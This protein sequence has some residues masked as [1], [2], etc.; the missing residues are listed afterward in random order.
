VRLDRGHIV[1]VDRLWSLVHPLRT[2]NA[3]DHQ[4]LRLVNSP[5]ESPQGEVHGPVSYVA[6]IVSFVRTTPRSLLL[7]LLGTH[8]QCVGRSLRSWWGVRRRARLRSGLG[9][10][11]EEAPLGVGGQGGVQHPGAERAERLDRPLGVGVAS[12]DV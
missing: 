3:A 2:L 9:E 10:R 11:G 6:A 8:A 4:V 7:A 1:I 12:D 5:A